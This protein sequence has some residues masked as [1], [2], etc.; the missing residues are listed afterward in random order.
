MTSKQHHADSAQ[1]KDSIFR[2]P[3]V[4]QQ[5]GNGRTSDSENAADADPIFAAIDRYRRAEAAS[6]EVYLLDNGTPP[7]RR[8]PKGELAAKRVRVTR[9][10]LARTI[11]TTREGLR[12]LIDYVDSTI[13]PGEDWLWD[14]W[15]QSAVGVRSIAR[16]V[17]RLM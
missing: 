1:P 11:P 14:G 2:K 15:H 3:A 4:R 6:H 9:H 5:P 10:L 17:R 13:K 16:A 8:T 7:T 12:Y